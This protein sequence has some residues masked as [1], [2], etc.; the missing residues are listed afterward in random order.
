M[1]CKRVFLIVLDSF[2]VGALPDAE[3]FG[4]TADSNTL[5]ACFETGILNIPNMIKLGI[6][7][8]P[9]VNYLKTPLKQTGACFR[10][11]E[12][13]M[14]KDTTTGHWEI[15]G[16]I[17]KKPFPTFKNGF[18][19]EIIN[20]IKAQTKRGVLCNKPYS[21]TEV[22]KD[23][24]DEH[25]R[26]GDLIIYTSADSVMQIAA[27]EKI[28]PVEK[29]Y[30]YCMMARKILCGKNAVG[31]VIARP[32]IL[33]DG[34]YVRTANRRDFSLQPPEKT[35]LDFINESG[36]DVISVGKIF[37]IFSGRGI[38][39]AFKTHSNDEGM[40]QTLKL[41]DEHIS[42]ICFTNLV[43]FDMLYGHRND[44]VG[45]AKALNRFDNWLGEF[46][47]K[48]SKDDLLIIT[49]DHGCDPSD[50]STDHTREYIPILVYGDSI[51]P[52]GY[53]TLDTYADIGASVCDYLNVKYSGSGKS[54][55]GRITG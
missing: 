52:G 27:D 44:A 16:I 43:D 32:F 31:R 33:K 12:K 40:S 5:K 2:G 23:Y 17:S 10:A 19:E 45:Y 55:M 49:A 41:A 34:S 29:L 3:K 11:A 37:D 4:D 8:I 35:M 25:E 13:S 1:S 7:N 9:G 47:K 14:G 15:A 20:E 42:G 22:I 51:V 50:V 30:E 36:K 26:T 21:G 28:V 24:G 48:L 46:L 54:F 39:K 38:T 18:P 53:G 6:S